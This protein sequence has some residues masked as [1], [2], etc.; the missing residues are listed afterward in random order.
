LREE[1]NG[2]AQRLP[3]SSGHGRNCF[4]RTESTCPSGAC[5]SWS[6]ASGSRRSHCLFQDAANLMGGD[7]VFVPVKGAQ[8]Q[9]INPFCSARIATRRPQ[10]SSCRMRSLPL[11][12]LQ[13]RRAPGANDIPGANKVSSGGIAARFP[14]PLK[15]GNVTARKRALSGAAT[16]GGLWNGSS[17]LASAGIRDGLRGI[18]PHL[19]KGSCCPPGRPKC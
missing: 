3:E 2:D 8:N 16:S 11:C 12:A 6:R 14:S 10:S 17:W 15:G 13:Q 1:E 5:P 9:F 19:D 18:P 4:L 7:A